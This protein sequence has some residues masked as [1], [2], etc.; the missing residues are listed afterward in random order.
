MS[1]LGHEDGSTPHVTVAGV[2]IHVLTTSHLVGLASTGQSNTPN[3]NFQVTLG[4][5]AVAQ[6]Q[7]QPP[8]LRP[9]DM[10]VLGAMRMAAH[11]I[12]LLLESLYM[13]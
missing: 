7:T 2:M 13:S 9:E 12:S 6:S 8:H 11:P 3:F 10:S 1:V 4:A 5:L